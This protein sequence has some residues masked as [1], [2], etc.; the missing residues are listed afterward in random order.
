MDPSAS[1]SL[2]TSWALTLT[3]TIS[4]YT[5]ARFVESINTPPPGAI[6][7]GRAKH[8]VLPSPMILVHLLVECELAVATLV[9][10]YQHPGE[11]L[12]ILIVFA[13]FVLVYLP[14]DMARYSSRLPKQQHVKYVRSSVESLASKYPPISPTL[15][16][17]S[18]ATVV[19][20]HGRIVVWYLPGVLTKHRQVCVLLLVLQHHLLIPW[21]NIG[22]DVEVA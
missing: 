8:P 19:D 17:T 5:Y 10:A 13:D 9:K 21:I 14:W 16:L 22:P 18:P 11:H 15:H 6:N 1:S 20:Q 7:S 3:D 2:P 12:V 4:A